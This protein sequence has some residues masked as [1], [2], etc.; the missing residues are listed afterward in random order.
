VRVA[1]LVFGDDNVGARLDAGAAVA[2]MRQAVV[3]AERG[4]LQ[5]PARVS[6]DLGEGRLVLCGS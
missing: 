1:P 5:A 2:A 6:A 3:D 4:V